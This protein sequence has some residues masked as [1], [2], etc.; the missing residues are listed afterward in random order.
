MHPCC[1]EPRIAWVR[2]FG[3][4]WWQN[5]KSR[6]TA[7]GQGE[8]VGLAPG[9]GATG[10]GAGERCG[11]VFE[12]TCGTL[13]ENWYGRK[14]CLSQTGEGGL[15]WAPPSSHP[16]REMGFTMPCAWAPP[17]SL[18]T[19]AP[20]TVPPSLSGLRTLS[21][22]KLPSSPLYPQQDK[23]NQTGPRDVLSV[24]VCPSRLH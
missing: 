13:W 6:A 10:E 11:S 4:R 7:E 22:S 17:C 24:S 21:P 19:P 8:G 5:W 20:V 14:P 3:R 9:I 18:P 15:L 2:C 12:G 23:R 16:P 1:S